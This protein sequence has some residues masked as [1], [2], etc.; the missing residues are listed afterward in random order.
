[1]SKP[2]ATNSAGLSAETDLLAKFARDVELAGLVGEQENAKI[3]LLA[4]ASAWLQKPINV[5]LQGA[6]SAGKNHLMA[7][8]AGF[9][10]DDHKKFLSGMSPKALMHSDATEFQH[11]AVFIA[12]YEGVAGAD[13]AIRTMQ[14]EQ[15]IE[16]LFVDSTKDGLQNKTARVRG[17]AAFIQATTRLRLHPENE[18]RLLFIHVD[19]SEAQTRAILRRQAQQAATGPLP[20]PENLYPSW[21]AH[22]RSLTLNKV[23]IPY[24]QR[25]AERFPAD[26]VCC[27]RDF[28]KLLALI[29]SSAFLHQHCRSQDGNVV[30]ASRADYGVAKLLFEHTQAGG[31]DRALEKLVRAAQ[32]YASPFRVPDLM[33]VLG[34]GKSKTYEVLARAEEPGYIVEDASVGKGCYRFEKAYSQ[35]PMDLPEP[36]SLG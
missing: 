25:L 15:T 5:T 29:E 19:E 16:Y 9:I 13:Y 26:R 36:E 12:E 8:V 1:M 11:K 3:V 2:D 32:E 21:H 4:A 34:W 24:A 18:T 30:I 28:P 23:C 35:A 17:P 22:L 31:P 7:C 14:S 20:V 10:P 33:P 6:S 27:R